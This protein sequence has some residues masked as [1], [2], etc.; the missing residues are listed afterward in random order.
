MW[1]N[2]FNEAASPRTWLEVALVIVTM[3]TTYGFAVVVLG[4][5]N[6]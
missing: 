3:V 4:G 2:V 5:C 1:S 6:G